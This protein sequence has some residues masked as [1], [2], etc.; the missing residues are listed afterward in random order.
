[1]VAKGGIGLLLG[2]AWAQ[3]LS[4]EAGYWLPTRD[5]L[6]ILVVFAE[7]DYGA[8]GED[9]YEKQYGNPWP[10]DA[11]GRT[12]PPLDAPLLLDA[13]TDD[14]LRG[15]VTRTYS[16]ASFGQLMILGDYVPWVVRVPCSWLPSSS[17]SLSEEVGLIVRA[18]GDSA[19]QTARGLSWQVFDRWQ[20]L[21]ARYGLPKLRAPAITDASYRPRLDALFIIWRNY[22]HRLGA[23]PPFSCN[24]GFGLWSCDYK[25]ALGPFTGGVE[26]ASSYTTCG[27][28]LGAGI[29]FLAE[30]FHGLY[31]G[32]HWHTNGGAGL[33]TF[34]VIST[35]RGLSVQGGGP[36]Y[37]IGYDRWL[38]GW[39][40]P[41]KVYLLSA[42]SPEGQ[43]VPTDLSQSS[44][45]QRWRFYLRDFMTSGDAVRIRLPY[46]E[47]GGSQ[48]KA[49]YLWLENRRFWASTEIWATYSA[50]RCPDNP[51][52]EHPRGVP[53]LYAYIQVGKDQKEGPDIYSAHPAHPNGLGSWIFWL[54]ADGRH[55][56]Y[57]DTL[58]RQAPNP[59]LPCNWG[60]RNIPIDLARSLPN[61]FLG[62]SD[63]YLAFDENTD[64]RLYSG[65]NS[66]LGLS[67]VEKDSVIHIYRL[68]GDAW[69]G[70]SK[71]SGRGR[72]GLGTN[73]APVPV[74]TLVSAEGYRGPSWARPAPY[75]N[76]VIW[77]S[78]LAVE[79]L[80][81]RSDG[82]LLIEVRWDDFV[83]R[84]AQRWC[85][86]I[87]IS[88]N[89][90]DS[91]APS[92]VIR[93]GVIVLDRSESP[94]YARGQV[95]D[96]TA[97]RWWFSD[98]TRL[99]LRRGSVV[100]LARGRLV[101]R[102]GSKLILEPG[103]VLR[104]Q[105]QIEVEPGGTVLIGPGARCTVPIRRRGRPYPAFHRPG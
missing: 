27:G 37:A 43:E 40:A 14:T 65:D 54:P 102:R 38:M 12:L 92:L 21:P 42:L 62:L 29:G 49:Q 67:Y 98:T 95:Y 80:E 72:L 58:R 9:P 59:A 91:L 53:G 6:Y 103:S 99:V 46:V 83:F 61:P 22:A 30:F 47:E 18:V 2:L 23:Q 35:V 82:A 55:D 85:G 74:Y 57:F 101:L 17:Y 7:V 26:L 56:Y 52:P 63:F 25:E 86:D 39:K 11:E 24:Y 81:E 78:G 41:G 94:V 89:P 68:G 32:N 8:C 5:T 73:P 51:F 19:F 104:G 64:G 1:M 88:R 13:T 16:E 90:F 71:K 105:G 97:K 10:R 3:V 48:V 45:P 77:L 4:T 84:G 44:E 60:H 20:L 36:I 15:L 100:E 31:G 50:Q 93:R 33:H 79:I 34:P 66:L 87:R 96:S 69:D 76:R 70:F 75:D 28:A